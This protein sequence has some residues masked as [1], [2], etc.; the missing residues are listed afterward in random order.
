MMKNENFPEKNVKDATAV[1]ESFKMIS[2][3][4]CSFETFLLYFKTHYTIKIPQNSKPELF[5]LLSALL[6]CIIS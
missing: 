4:S 5:F 1:L 3:T 2:A 6:C